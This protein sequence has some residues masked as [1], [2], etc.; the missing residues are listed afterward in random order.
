MAKAFR[1][2]LIATDDSTTPEMFGNQIDTMLKRS[3]ADNDVTICP[4][5]DDCKSPEDHTSKD[6]KLQISCTLQKAGLE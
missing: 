1:N 5:L 2:E 6:S 3:L 4:K